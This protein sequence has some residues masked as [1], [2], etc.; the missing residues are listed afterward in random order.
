MNTVR[1]GL[2]LI[3]PREDVSIHT[4][5]S[6]NVH[7]ISDKPYFKMIAFSQHLRHGAAKQQLDGQ[8]SLS[9]ANELQPR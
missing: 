3:C 4:L 7:P 2:D 8:S 5:T 6:R 9:T 1:F